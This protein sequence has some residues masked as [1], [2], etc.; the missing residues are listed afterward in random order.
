VG[1]WEEAERLQNEVGRLILGVSENT[2]GAMVL[3][4]L[5]LW[6]LRARRVKIVLNF[7]KRLRDREEDDL[8]RIT[9]RDGRWERKVCK[10]IEEFGL[11]GWDARWWREDMWRELVGKIAETEERS[12]G[13]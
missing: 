2:A 10:W 12:D 5:G 4:E 1:E 13:G 11:D 6:K 9:T 7:W 3:G 8:C